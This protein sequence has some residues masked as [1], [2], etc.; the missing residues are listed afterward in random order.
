[1]DGGSTHDRWMAVLVVTNGG[2]SGDN[3][4]RRKNTTIN[5]RQAGVPWLFATMA[6]VI[7][8]AF[9]WAAAERHN[10]QK[11]MGWRILVVCD[12][13]CSDS[14]RILLMIAG[15]QRTTWKLHRDITADGGN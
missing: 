3:G 7:A 4:R 5:K 11:E 8:S 15:N 10:N 13:G 9:R 1:M 14:I 12:N 2:I 6:T